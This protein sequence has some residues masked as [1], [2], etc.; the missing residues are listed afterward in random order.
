[1]KCLVTDIKFMNR[2]LLHQN[3]SQ[4]KHYMDQDCRVALHI[5][6]GAWE[7]ELQLCESIQLMAE[8]NIQYAMI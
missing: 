1:M 3:T 8:Q 2:I 6:T 5:M 7:M 4:P